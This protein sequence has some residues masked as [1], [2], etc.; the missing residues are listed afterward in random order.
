MVDI[1]HSLI[2]LESYCSENKYRGFDPYDALKSPLFKTTFLKS[3]KLIRFA[4][5]QIV[6]RF[7]LN[8]RPVLGVPKGY[9]PVTLG[10]FIQGYSY[11]SKLNMDPITQ[12]YCYDK[13]EILLNELESMVPSGY[14]GACWG[15][16]FDWEARNAYIPAYQPTVVATGI[17]TN[18]LFIAYKITGNV[19]CSDLVKSSAKF[20]LEDLNRTYSG[21]SYIFSYSPFD[22]QKVFNASMKGIRILSQAYNLTQNE[23]FRTEA[24]QGVNFVVSNQQKNGAWSYSLASSGGWSDNYHSGYI[25]DCLSDY[26]DLCNDDE[27]DQSL[28]TGY[29]FYLNSFFETDGR[30]RFFHDRSWPVDC[31][32][33]AQSILTLSRFDNSPK[34][35]MVAEYMLANMQS[36]AGGFYFRKYR[37]HTE[38]TIFMR[39]SNAWMFASLSYLLFKLQE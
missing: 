25:L 35:K 19:K 12:T 1:F 8:L 26:K 29:E 28:K 18:A 30:P 3:N 24:K 6:K 10:L 11:L 13:I 2:R 16:D 37:L 38:K 4:T 23:L 7:P 36:P 39:W 20:V 27:Y 5:Q 22:H 34:A 14:H 9:N 17:I 31:T 32:S 15:Y 21:D 33:G